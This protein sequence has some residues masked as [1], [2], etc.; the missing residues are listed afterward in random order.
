M[1]RI[2]PIVWV[3]CLA[4]STVL[5]AAAADTPKQSGDKGQGTKT[6]KVKAVQ[7]K[8]DAAT[9]KQD[10][11]SKKEHPAAKEKEARKLARLVRMTLKGEYPEGPVSSGIF[12]DLKP[13]LRTII[14]RIDQA[15]E[16]QDVDAVVL[17]IEDLGLGQGKV[18]ELRAAI[19]RFRKHGKPIYA[20]LTS[21]DTRQYV[22]AIA[23]DEVFM[24]CSGMLIMPGLRAEMTFYKGLFDKLGIHFDV[25]QE[26]KYKGAG[27]PFT[28]SAMSKPLR[29]SMEA[30]VDDSYNGVVNTIAKD[31]K[32]PDYQVKTL[33]DQGLFTAATAKKAG[34]IDRIA[35]FDEFQDSLKAKL[36]VRQ[37]KLVSDYKKK[38]VDADF[39]GI[40]GMVKLMELL[41]GGKTAEKT[42]REQK[43]AVVYATGVIVE[44]SGTSDM[45][46]GEEGL[47]STKLI[48]ALRT[49]D[50]DAKVVAIVLR[51]D[52]PGG[53]AVASDLIWREIVRIKKPVIASMSDVAGSGGYYIAMGT[54][55]I[56]AAPDTLTG[57]IGVIGGKLVIGGLLDKLGVTTEVIARG[58]NSGSM[59]MISRFTPSER[60]AWGAL[61][62]ETYLQ[63]VKKA[64][65]GRKMPEKKLQDLAQGRVYTGRMAVANGLVDSIGTLDDAIRAAKVAAHLKP[66]TKVELLILPKAK[67][68]FEQLFGDS[69]VTTEADSILPGL[70][71]TIRQA[72]LWKR[73]FS[74]PRLML[75][76]ARIELK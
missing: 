14:E 40:S 29:E 64:A 19:A 69:N 6:E 66:E 38:Q 20:E 44:G 65:A 51:I 28:R 74:E 48:Q 45:F 42:S 2:I 30:L 22:L 60:E 25:L 62:D 54:R 67:S 33:I 43:I 23:C 9:V 70:G 39:S 31:R 57:S 76:P 72:A 1:R 17:T 59:S 56:F 4:F 73:V 68:F 75:M 10:G 41:F 35:Y 16:D 26:G 53:S 13:S 27:E 36:K 32:L 3:V 47:G 8:K 37:I 21:A 61:L 15:A 55:K 7:S 46:G 18:Y 12:G 58:K 71:G 49:A 34:L 11:A 24:P 50:E 52:S 5:S 63:F